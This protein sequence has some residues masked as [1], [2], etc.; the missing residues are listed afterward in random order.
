MSRNCNPLSNPKTIRMRTQFAF[1]LIVLCFAGLAVGCGGP[2]GPA[3]GS[4][5]MEELIRQQDAAVAA[6]ESSL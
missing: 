4:P 1:L 3:I 2:D 6:D 5:E